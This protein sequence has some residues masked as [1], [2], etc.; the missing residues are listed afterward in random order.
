[1]KIKNILLAIISVA[2]TIV[3]AESIC[4]ETQMEDLV[5]AGTPAFSN[6]AFTGQIKSNKVIVVGE[7]HFFTDLKPRLDLI[8]EYKRLA[9]A[10]AC[11]AF[12]LAARPVGTEV[13]LATLK[14]GIDGLKANE[15]FKK[16]PGSFRGEPPL[17]RQ[18]S[19]A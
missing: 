1:M 16:R 8:K 2:S 18:F 3:H 12:E 4:S 5:K 9:G 13:S 19:H 15:E 7:I 11:V 10:N 14:S 6:D 17:C